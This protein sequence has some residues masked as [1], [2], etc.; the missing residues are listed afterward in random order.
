MSSYRR[1]VRT[2]S[3]ALLLL[4]ASLARGV[5][6]VGETLPFTAREI[7]QGYRDGFVIAKPKAAQRAASDTAEARE[8]LR[9][10]RRWDRLDGMRLLELP[11]GDSPLQ[12]EARLR[13]TGRYEFVQRD[14]IRTATAT[15]NDPDFASRQWPLRNDGSN[16]GIAGADIGAVNAWDVRTDASEIVVAVIDSGV[17]YDHPDL[18]ANMWTNAREIPGNGRDD[19]GNGYVD[20]VFGI[21]AI[22][23]GG[24]PLDDLGHGTHVAGIIGAVGNNGAG[25]AGVAWKVRIM[26][27]KFLR[28][29]T[30][31]NAGRGATSDGIECIDYAIRHGAHII[32]GSYGAAAGPVT[33]FDPAE[34]EA[35]L[36]ARAA[37]IIFVAAAGNDAANMEL[38]AHYP[39]SY[40]LENVISVANST[41]RDDASISTNFGAGSVE[42]FAP[43]T[44]IWSTWY[45]AATPYALRS[46]TS[47]AAPHVAGALA[48][49]KAQFPGDS[50]RQVINR[51]LGTVDPVPA[52]RGRVQ[53]GG[54]L[55]LDR[56]LRSTDNRPFNDDF[57]RRSRLAGNNFT[58]RNVSTGATVESEPAI[59]GFN[60]AAS[61]W[62]EW[63]PT[64]SGIVRLSTAGSG[65]DTLLGVF[66]G[67]SLD[68]LSPV[69]A[70][71]DDTGLTT[72]RLEFSAQ[73]GTAYQIVVAGKNGGQGL[74]LLDLGAIAANDQ[75]AAAQVI[76]GRSAVIESANAQA[77][78]EPG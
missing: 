72:S 37:G 53:T 11:P 67:S 69:A 28:G 50:Y 58:V 6:P 47:M 34:R 64:Q 16:N 38:L 43:G 24:N 10:R 62:W 20:D 41:A 68:A 8:G 32:N 56:A 31:T 4:F 2:T 14:T 7:A 54:R 30:G 75:F 39:A 70:S 77:T 74:V 49:V 63:T 65:F 15:P 22:T 13:A 57:T 59:A 52:F 36:R 19:D 18:A 45:T 66:T 71:D 61:L 78:L 26:A 76:A 9:V 1:S 42:L 33:Q 60:G 23:N 40:R 12:A 3:F 25:I 35:I 29:G 17:K 73:A 44:E 27:L 55:N 51:V 46:G 48:L 21:N 5:T